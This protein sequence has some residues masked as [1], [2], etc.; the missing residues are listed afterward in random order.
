MN[1]LLDQLGEN[2]DVVSLSKNGNMQFFSVMMLKQHYSPSWLHSND[3][4][5]VT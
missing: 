4:D 3:D 1:K 2:S 5:M